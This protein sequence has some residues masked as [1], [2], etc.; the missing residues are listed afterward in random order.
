MC[1][2]QEIAGE[3]CWD[4]VKVKYR[5][6]GSNFF[7]CNTLLCLD[8]TEKE[9]SFCGHGK[10]NFLGCQCDGGCRKGGNKHSVTNAFQQQHPGREYIP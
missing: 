8:G 4:I 10:C 9:G 6:E 7:I 2:Y 5:C 1:Y 3:C